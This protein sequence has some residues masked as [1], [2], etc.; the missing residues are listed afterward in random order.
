[1]DQRLPPAVA[2]DDATPA[3]P[4]GDAPSVDPI[5]SRR[6]VLV[7]LMTTM[8]LAA[9]D[10]TIVSTAIPQIVGELGGFSLFTWVF[11]VY[12][13][14]QTVTIPV[15]GKLADQ[16]GRKPILMGGMVIFLLG[17]T[18]C[19][20]A[21]D[22]TSLIAFRGVQALGAGA[23]MATVNT[24]AGD[25][26]SLK[27]RARI[28][29][30]LSSAWGFS[31]IVGP[32]LGGTFAEHAN[33]RWIFLINL[34]VGALAMVL[35]GKNLHETFERHKHRIDVAGA[36]LVFWTIGLLMFNLSQA[37]DAWGWVSAPSLGIFGLV[38]LLVGATIWVERRAAEPILPGWLWRRRVFSATNFA[39]VC[40]GIVMMG[41]I[42][43]LPM[44][45][46]S[47]FDVGAIFAGF[48]LAT[49]SLSW[50]ISSSMS[51]RLYLRIGFRDTALIGAAIVLIASLGFLLLPYPGSPWLVILDQ[52]AFGAGF[53]LMSTPLLV[54][55]QAAV[56]WRQRGVV[57]GANM[58]SRYLGQSLGAAIFG[59]IFNAS[60]A[61]QVAQAPPAIHA[62]LPTSLDEMIAALRD[63]ALDIPLREFLRHAVSS[64]TH[65]IYLGMAVV[66][67]LTFVSLLIAPRHFPSIDEEPR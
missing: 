32:V 53:G 60:M 50:P 36:M 41:P 16:Y 47:V 48:I 65:H 12:M 42:A 58:F 17:S 29:G 14:V 43:Y 28:Q 26:F 49:T 13:L 3:V 8:M 21:W 56:G 23:V 67:A 11:S 30:W 46:Q 62:Q 9:M 31:A 54:G 37:G 52:L 51:G 20:A 64:S 2:K 19:G 22:M 34:P 15:Y 27:E 59:V 55:V 61:G 38:L 5:V 10:S 40:M 66:A 4:R 57:T 33:W 63:S 25:L 18:L 39:M 6:W 7:G 1:M 44:F 24:L 45:A 35:I